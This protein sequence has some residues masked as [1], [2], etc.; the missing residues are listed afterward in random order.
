MHV[1]NM[2]ESVHF[3]RVVI[4]MGIRVLI[5]TGIV[6]V[7]ATTALAESKPSAMNLPQDSAPE[8]SSLIVKTD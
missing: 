6:C 3:K 1:K 4:K 8:K 2:A 5:I 7:M